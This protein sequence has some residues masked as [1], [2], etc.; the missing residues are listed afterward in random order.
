MVTL[1]GAY[2]E[3]VNAGPNMAMAVNF[4]PSDWIGPPENYRFCRRRHH[5]IKPTDL[6]IRQRTG[7]PRVDNIEEIR[8]ESDRSSGNSLFSQPQEE[9][10][11]SDQQD[12][13]P[14]NSS[15]HQSQEEDETD[16]QQNRPLHNTLS[17]Q[18]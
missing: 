11:I 15:S 6:R 18:S 9:G 2:H 1:P 5:R 12:K 13:P 14:Y 8:E 4:A 3:V 16:E 10:E 7:G 17:P